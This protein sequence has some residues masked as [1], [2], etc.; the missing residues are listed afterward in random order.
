VPLRT[1]TT[2]VVL[3]HTR[4][5]PFTSLP[6]TSKDAIVLT[7]S[8]GYRYLWIDALCIVQDDALDWEREAAEYGP[9]LPRFGPHSI[10]HVRQDQ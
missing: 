5:I 1:T 3:D 2:N 10:R 9:N 6:E 4:Y 7:R 8:L